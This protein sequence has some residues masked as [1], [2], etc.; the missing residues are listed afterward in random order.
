MRT[1]RRCC[2]PGCKN[3]AVAT[4][5]YVYSDSTA[6][7]GP[8]ATVAEPHSWDLCEMHGSRI[9]APKGWELVRYEGAFSSA[10][11]DEDDLTALAEAVREAGLGERSR[12][13]SGDDAAEEPQRAVVPPTARTGRRG[14]LRVL[15]DPT[16]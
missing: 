10:T 12:P 2:R 1:L 7:V 3:P 6:V 11:P 4:L 5:T 8:L 9:T 13:D 16:S 15:P 14:H